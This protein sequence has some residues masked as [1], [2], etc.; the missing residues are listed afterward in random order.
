[1]FVYVVLVLWK[2]MYLRRRGKLLRFCR[3][4][5]TIE[6]TSFKFNYELRDLYYSISARV[7]ML[8]RILA[9]KHKYV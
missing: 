2:S 7:Y 8:F 5:I 9:M 4:L 1:M 3:E 6:N